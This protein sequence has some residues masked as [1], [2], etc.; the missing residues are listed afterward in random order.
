M[1]LTASDTRDDYTVAIP[2]VPDSINEADEG[3]MLVMTVNEAR[4]SINMD[5]IAFL[6][7]GVALAKIKDDDCKYLY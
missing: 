6:G 2:I 7:G 5:E 1:L 3:F 4:S